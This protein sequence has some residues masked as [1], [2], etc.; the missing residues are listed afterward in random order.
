MDSQ[1]QSDPSQ[2][3]PFNENQ[4]VN[5]PQKE[6]FEASQ[7]DFRQGELTPKN[8]ENLQRETPNTKLED[9]DKLT[10]AEEFDALEQ[11]F[12][13]ATDFL[14]GSF[15]T[16]VNLV[17]SN[18]KDSKEHE[19]KKSDDKFENFKKELMEKTSPSPKEESH[20]EHHPHHQ[21]HAD[22]QSF[23]PTQE[24]KMLVEEV[25]EGHEHHHLTAD[26]QSFKPNHDSKILTEKVIEGLEDNKASLIEKV[27][28]AEKQIEEEHS[29]QESHRT[30]SKQ[31]EK[32]DSN[33]FWFAEDGP[34]RERFPNKQENQE[35]TSEK[36][37]ERV[38]LLDHV[39]HGYQA[40]SSTLSYMKNLISP[41]KAK[42][43]ETSE[44]VQKEHKKDKKEKREVGAD[45]T[46]KADSH[47]E[48]HEEK[49]P[50][51]KES[52]TQKLGR[53]FSETL[54]FAAQEDNPKIA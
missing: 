42:I 27:E 11:G 20:E 52:W 46:N 40:V 1:R 51:R 54:D 41:A 39:I 47:E 6:N 49:R 32:R 4:E 12:H 44:N 29:H 22:S 31:M 5:F 43:E 8:E 16:I 10:L 45:I 2:E 28:E 24:S 3:T 15:D 25:L 18:D 14:A 9:K 30:P 17:R 26:S 53:K 37:E 38:P 48:E 19:S 34:V 23:K 21:L 7:K 13:Y 50:K 35:N 33:E 36:Q